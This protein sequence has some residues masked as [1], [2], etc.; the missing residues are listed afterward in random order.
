MLCD[1]LFNNVMF[2]KE[3]DSQDRIFQFSKYWPVSI[4]QASNI[5][6][7]VDF[8]HVGLCFH[9]TTFYCCVFN[10]CAHFKFKKRSYVLH[11]T[12]ILYN[13]HAFEDDQQTTDLKLKVLLTNNN[14]LFQIRCDD[15]LKIR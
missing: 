14:I 1:L 13:Y 9:L 12:F 15:K 10:D 11:C 7:P 8:G 4:E 2:S 6:N 3:Q 5:F